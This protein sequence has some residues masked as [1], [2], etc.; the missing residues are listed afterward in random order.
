MVLITLLIFRKISDSKRQQ[1]TAIDYKRLINGL[2]LTDGF[3]C[4]VKLT[5]YDRQETI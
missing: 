4:G 1:T 5:R 3:L 2:F